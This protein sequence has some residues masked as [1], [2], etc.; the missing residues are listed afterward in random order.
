M[1]TDSSDF[2]DVGKL[3]PSARRQ[4]PNRRRC[5]M[6]DV[7]VD[8][9]TYTACIGLYSDDTPGELF[10]D[11]LKPGSAMAATLQD[12]AVAVSIALQHGVKATEMAKSMS[13]QPALAWQPSAEPASVIGASLDLMEGMEQAAE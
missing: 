3:R 13:R 10:L 4:L 7:T 2:P 1:T 5:I 9:R 8:N 12:S 11:G 6:H